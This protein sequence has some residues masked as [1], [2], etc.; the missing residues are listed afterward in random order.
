MIALHIEVPYGSF[1]KSYARSFAETYPFPPPATVYGMLL[2]VV[3]EW[4]RSRHSGVQL[5]FAYKSQ[6]QIATTLRKL[7]RYKYGVASKQS[8]LGNA[9]DFVET[10]CN[11]DF[12]CWV[13]S[14]QE[15]QQAQEDLTDR[16]NLESRLIA[17]IEHPETVTRSG[18][19]SLG[20]SDDAVNELS[21]FNP[22]CGEWH[23]LTPAASGPIE[24]PIWVDHVGSI[25]TRWQ[26]YNFDPNCS[27]MPQ[28]PTGDRF[29]SITDPR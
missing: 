7:S 11:I 12:I 4:R 1:R 6:P 5:A 24:L 2:S 8:K 29:T 9:P 23:W 26:R 13:N 28:N 18:I 17:A 21:L 16:P 14:S 15:N 25:H 10:L 27:T 22:V 19:V 20:L 3:G